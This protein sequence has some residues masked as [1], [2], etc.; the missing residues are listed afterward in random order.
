MVEITEFNSFRASYSG[1]VKRFDNF[2]QLVE[3]IASKNT[4]TSETQSEYKNWKNILSTEYEVNIKQQL[5]QENK[6]FLE[7]TISTI[8]D[9]PEYQAFMKQ[10]DSISRK[11]NAAKDIGGF[12]CGRFK[13]THRCKDDFISSNIL[14]LDVDYADNN[15]LDDVKK[16]CKDYAYELISTMIYSTHSSSEKQRKYRMVIPLS[17]QVNADEYRQIALV[18]IGYL[19]EHNFDYHSVE[20]YR[21]YIYPSCC[22]DAKTEMFY[23]AG[24]QLNVEQIINVY[25]KCK[26]AYE[27]LFEHP[28]IKIKK[29]FI[30]NEKDFKGVEK[31]GVGER[32][33]ALVKFMGKLARQQ[34][35]EDKAWNLINSFNQQ[36]LT[37][38]LSDNEIQSAFKSGFLVWL[39]KNQQ[40]QQHRQE[41]LNALFPNI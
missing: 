7:N 26:S 38:P 34:V 35:D 15:F 31:I 6:I 41:M 4:V 37:P 33:S 36:V 19:G 17:R 21:Y 18:I 13:G 5:Y 23:F 2:Y 29:S 40:E 20:S 28:Q 9:I 25:N 14:A 27:D 10:Q 12:C 30:Y 3:Y 22:R 24:D 11:L 39:R 16:F 8:E 32:N 1:K